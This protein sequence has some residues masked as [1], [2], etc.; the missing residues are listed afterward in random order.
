V[1]RLR[2]DTPT[3]LMTLLTLT[4][5]LTPESLLL[6]PCREAY[7]GFVYS[8]S[9]FSFRLFSH[10]ELRTQLSSL[11]L[12]FESALLAA[13]LQEQRLHFMMGTA[14]SFGQRFATLLQERI[15]LIASAYTSMY[16]CMY[17]NR[18]SI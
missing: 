18:F 4:V 9:A 15:D 16:K 7:R 11:R 14:V 13:V 12:I 1:P 10:A 6:F 5:T 17:V 3:S 2:V 8:L